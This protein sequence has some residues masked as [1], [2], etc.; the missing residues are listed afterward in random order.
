M[1]TPAEEAD[2][3]AVQTRELAD[4]LAAIEAEDDRV[5]SREDVEKIISGR[6]A[7]EREKRRRVEADRDE[8]EAELEGLRRPG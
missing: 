4:R 6:L 2:R 3:I 1:R 5:L 7:R 8:L